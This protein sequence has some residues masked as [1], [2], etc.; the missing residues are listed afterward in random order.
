MSESI[1]NWKK[2]WIFFIYCSS[3]G[4]ITF[5]LIKTPMNE[6]VALLMCMSWI[7]RIFDFCALYEISFHKFADDVSHVFSVY[8]VADAWRKT[9]DSE[10]IKCPRWLKFQDCKLSICAN[11][12]SADVCADVCGHR[13]TLKL[14]HFKPTEA[15]GGMADTSIDWPWHCDGGWV[16]RWCVHRGWHWTECG[17]Y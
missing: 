6:C 11:P 5:R 8:K 13:Q 14:R 2:L 16:L 7:K 15:N 1:W 10:L 9:F 3:R 12:H 4:R 17:M